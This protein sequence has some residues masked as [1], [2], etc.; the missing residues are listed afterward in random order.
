MPPSAGI[1]L[2]A[3]FAWL[4]ALAVVTPAAAQQDQLPAADELIDR[5]VEALGGREALLRH[6]SSRAGGHFEMPAAGIKGDLEVLSAAPNLVVTMV[7]IPGIGVMR[8]GFDGNV[9]WSVDPMM[10]PR[11]LSGGELQALRDQAHILA[12]VRDES[13]FTARETVER[14]E[15]DGVSC[16]EVRLV[17]KSGRET[18]DCYSPETGLLVATR[19]RQDSPMGAVEVTTIHG[20]YREFGRVRLATR[21]TQQMM[22]QQQ[23]MTLTS[24]DFDAVDPK[25]FTPP[26]EIQALMKDK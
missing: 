5:Y 21:L 22:G 2:G 16:I 15:V 8:T 19:A 6:K 17:W 7:T 25:A 13:L 9:G 3:A 14:T 4:L 23:V 1:R 24:V 12:A 26:P 20:D 10:G 11:L 18:F